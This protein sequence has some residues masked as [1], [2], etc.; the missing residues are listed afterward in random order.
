MSY[1]K[2]ET[3]K[4]LEQGGA[5]VKGICRAKQKSENALQKLRKEVWPRGYLYYHSKHDKKMFKQATARVGRAYPF[6]KA[7]FKPWPF[8]QVEASVPALRNAVLAGDPP[9]RC[10]P[11]MED[12][13]FEDKETAWRAAESAQHLLNC[14][15]AEDLRIRA[16]MGPIIRDA[17]IYGTAVLRVEW[18]TRAG[19]EWKQVR[20]GT[21]GP[22]TFKQAQNAEGQPKR[23][24]KESRVKLVHVPIWNFF[25]DMRGRSI[26]G[27]GDT[28]PCRYVVEVYT[29]PV[30]DLISWM[31]SSPLRGWNI[32][33][34]MR[35]GK[36][37][38]ARLRKHL[39]PITGTVSSDDDWH[40]FTEQEVGK[41]DDT[42]DP[43]DQEDRQ[44]VRIMA[45]WEGG[46]DPRH[47]LV[48][49]DNNGGMVLL[50][51]HGKNHPAVN[52]GI[53]YAL[54][55]PIPLAHELFGLSIIEELA[56]IVHETNALVNLHLAGLI[57]AINGITIVNTSSGIK[58][59][60]LLS[61]PGGIVETD[62]YVPLKECVEHIGFEN[63]AAAIYT[64]TVDD[65]RGE[66]TLGYGATDP[67]LGTSS[68]NAGNTARGTLAQIEQGSR[69][70]NLEA[71]TIG[72][73][74]AQVGRIMHGLNQQYITKDRYAEIAS[75]EG[76]ESWVTVG[77]KEIGLNYRIYFDTR[78]VVTNEGV[79]TQSHINFAQIGAQ[80]PEFNRSKWIV[81]HARMTHQ[82]NP[83]DYTM[84][85]FEEPQIENLLWMQTGTFPNV[86]P[87]DNH[88]YHE[89]V[90]W[91]VGQEAQQRGGEALASFEQHMQSHQMGGQPAPQPGAGPQGTGAP[92]GPP[93][94]SGPPG[95]YPQDQYQGQPYPDVQGAQRGGY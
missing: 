59:K 87:G 24:T 78:P 31:L 17:K 35:E 28:Q 88:G 26:N 68:T 33:D 51:D 90:H 55:T 36:G 13:A 77:P 66:A 46:D 41:R 23:V 16:K 63:P 9:F 53:P 92:E 69:R 4:D 29:L 61:Q 7:I 5:L 40:K 38:R 60:N 39:E 71:E 95:A 12:E 44:L 65:L 82:P 45:F 37:R 2:Q 15:F 54:V 73:S 86:K 27:E 50:H 72:E 42:G 6:E 52:A 70:W 11:Y 25:P 47:I 18:F 57:R 80:F 94:Q 30:D 84:Q 75:K 14:Q 10:K 3:Y 20:E 91:E 62:G 48:A 32:P 56:G 74:F 21:S 49:G 43:V 76:A 85:Q 67:M 81:D 1:F 79:R 8:Q 93:G 19:P 64:H 22:Y 58:A 89:D 34:A 83:S